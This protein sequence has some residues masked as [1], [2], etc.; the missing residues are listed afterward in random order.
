MKRKINRKK[1]YWILGIVGIVLVAGGFGLKTWLSKRSSS[2]QSVQTSKVTLG[3]VSTTISGSGTVRSGQSS[4]INWQTSGTVA[5]VNVQIGQQVK[6]GDV[7][8]TLD[9]TSLSSSIIQAQADLIDA[10]TALDDLLKP[11][12]LQVAQAEAALNTAQENLDNLLNPTALT[13]AKGESAV[14]DAQ[15]ALDILLHPT[16]LSI[17]QAESAV[18]DAQTALNN[19]LSPD[20]KAVS[21][22]ET[23]VQTAQTALDDAQT[24][25][26]RLKYARSSQSAIDT[27]R[28]TLVVAEDEVARAQD[29]YD[30]TGGD[31]LTD[32][33]KAQ[34]LSVLD[35]AKKKRDKA[36]ATLNWYLS[37]W[38][39]TE[40]SER[41]NALTLAKAT[42]AD[43]Q[44]TLD[45]LKNPSAADIA[46]AQGR[47]SDAQAA[48][49]TLMNPTAVDIALAQAQVNDAQKALDK[50]KN[51]TAVDIELA[52]QQVADAQDT[53]N[54]LKNGAS[55]AD[56]T[57][58]KSRVTLAEATLTQAKIT[59]PFAGT[60]TDVET[61]AGDKVSTG[62]TAF[63]I[64]DLSKM[65][66]DLSISEVDISQ[67][68][69]GQKATL[70]F[71]A[72]SNKEF[73]GV[74][75]KV[76]MAGTVSQGVV[77]YPVTVQLTDGD[78]SVL[79]GMTSSVN[80]ITA[81]SAN[82]LVVPNKAVHT[83]GTQRTVTVLFQG[84]QIQVPVTVGLVGDSYTEIT[85]T[86][87]KE[88]DVVVVSTTTGTTSSSTTTQ[89]GFDQGGGP[90]DFPGGGVIIGP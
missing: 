88:G 22:A 27:A 24:A 89:R 79:S 50:I 43:A 7:L 38:S 62:T 25:V 84:Q 8:A 21:E 42:L 49:D 10:Q 56:I 77:N 58:A 80:L 44:K 86:T 32:A 65:Y 39:E 40:I 82:V 30:H 69:V 36:L 16:A 46:L 76:V 4:T 75:T 53:V 51:P 3:T 33:Y 34:A 70:T 71:D 83:L 64:D 81:E 48:L 2:T 1:L 6:V 47:V 26:D 74:I 13:I 11:Q 29:K 57:V 67:I 52:K 54:T 14:T 78:A 31:P 85:G 66:V 55:E 60:V 90:I 73:N 5:T 19:L 87:L 61:L 41:N 72:I 37:A 23:A 35:A 68:Q 45:S 18:T 20:P 15:K 17:A 9:P 28:A 59:A 12:P 63:R